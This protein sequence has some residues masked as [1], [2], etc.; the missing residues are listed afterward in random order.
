MFDVGVLR[1]IS[2]IVLLV[3]SSECGYSLSASHI[4]FIDS[5]SWI[6]NVYLLAQSCPH[7]N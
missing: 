7:R 2:V 6:F 3:S 4:L 5:W 1:N